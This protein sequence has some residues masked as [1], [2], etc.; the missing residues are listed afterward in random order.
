LRVEGSIEHENVV[1]GWVRV[2][3]FGFRVSGSGFRDNANVVARVNP[4]P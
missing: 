3:G 4:R 2:S 1:R